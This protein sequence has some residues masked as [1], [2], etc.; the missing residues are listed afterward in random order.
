[1]DPQALRSKLSAALIDFAWDEWAQMGIFAPTRRRSRWAQDPEALLLLTLEVGRDDPRLFDEVLD[2]LVRNESLLSMRRMTSLADGTDDERLS[3]A[4][5][6]WATKQKRPSGTKRFQ[7]RLHLEKEPLFRTDEVGAFFADPTFDAMGFVRPP[8]EPSGKSRAP[9]LIA[10]I[11][12]A[13]RLRQILGVGTRSEALRFLLT[14][15]VDG[16]SV[17]DIASAGGYSKRNMHEALQALHSAGV[18]SA[19]SGDG[20]QRYTADRT[21]WAHL[22]AAEPE[23]LPVYRDWP[24]FLR[25]LRR[26]LRWLGRPDLASLSEYILTSQAADLLDDVRPDL[27]R[28]GVVMPGRQG[29]A[30]SWTDLEETIDYALLWLAPGGARSPGGA[31]QLLRDDSGG[32]RWRL[33]AP[34]GRIVATSA[35]TYSS[36]T[37]ARAA[38]DRLRRSETRLAYKVMPDAG[39]YRWNVVADNGRILAASAEAF[40]TAPDAERAARDARDLAAGAAPAIELES[41]RV[42]ADRRHVMLRGDGMWQVQAD[43]ATRASSVHRSQADAIRAARTLLR[44]V[45]GAEVLVHRPDGTIRD[46]DTIGSGETRS[47]QDRGAS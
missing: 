47:R 23:D 41:E 44:N 34:S 38:V 24:S 20:E 18:V 26:M 22:L 9:D 40:A 46:A 8:A 14:A 15:D 3:A 43:G 32:H 35:E 7:P 17:A 39:A 16:A 30:R 29:D 31:F 4:A 11:N 2:W 5:M 25:A 33:M 45:D 13:F 36:A 6:A 1:M 19:V 37:S 27:N 12:F 21:R 10:P 42:S 28:A